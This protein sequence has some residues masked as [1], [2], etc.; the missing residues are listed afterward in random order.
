M[1]A[2]SPQS[3]IEGP[4]SRT[5]VSFSVPVLISGIL[6]MLDASV[7]AMWVGRELGDVALAALSNANLLWALL[8]A[9]AFGVSTAGTV[10]IGR[11]L[12]AGDMPSAKAAFGTTLSASAILSIIC[13]LPM[14]IWARPLL[15]C[16]GTPA[17]ALAPGSAYLK[18]LLLS[19]PFTYLYWTVAAALRSVGDSKTGVYFS[20]VIIVI[21]A[22]LNPLLI[23]GA[24]PMPRLGIAGSALALT[25][26]QVAG[27]CALLGY[28]YLLRHPISL[29]RRDLPLLRIDR[30]IMIALLRKAGPMAVQY[31]WGSIEEML[32]ISL[33][34]RFGPDATAA[35]GAAIQ[36][37]TF[38]LMPAAALGVAVTSVVAQNIGAMQWDRV[39]KATYISLGYSVLATAACVALVEAFDRQAFGI[40]LRPGS[41]AFAFTTEINREATW[42]LIF[43]GGYAVWVGVL[44]ARGIVWVPLGISAGVIAVRYPATVALLGAW[45]AHAIWWSFPA[46][47]AAT[48]AVAGVY[49]WLRRGG[50]RVT[51]AASTSLPGRASSRI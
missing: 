11:S 39:R 10:W 46:S 44:R 26:G 50:K 4:L 48:A 7:N 14:A 13:V 51:L 24:G 37:W 9:G 19:V 30:T 32:M 31:L 1:S 20:I 29:G 12:G 36:L 41:P 8:V 15:A 16:L 38:I 5:L 25:V 33:V 22:A 35:Y 2:G 17:P 27:L 40:F 3:L 47:A 21:D 34:N 23:T 49:G 18:V 42:A 28:L 43:F 6:G 45:H